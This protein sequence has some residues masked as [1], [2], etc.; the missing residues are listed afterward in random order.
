MTFIKKIL[1]R[2]GWIK[3][4]PTIETLTTTPKTDKRVDEISNSYPPDTCPPDDITEP[5]VNMRSTGYDPIKGFRVELDWNDA[6]IQYLRDNGF[7]GQSE[8][9]I[10]QKWVGMLYGNIVE[11]LDNVIIDRNSSPDRKSPFQ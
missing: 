3:S 1:Q 9:E 5:W 6:F 4:T 7:V 2:W 10:V 11:R 8:E